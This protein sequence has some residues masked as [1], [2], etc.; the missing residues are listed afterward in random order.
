MKRIGAVLI[1]L[2]AFVAAAYPFV[3]TSSYFR[4]VGVLTLM[5]AALATSWNI[6]G[7]FTGYISLGHS[8]FFGVGAY[9]AGLLITRLSVPSYASV[10]IAGVGVG[11]AAVAVGYVAVRVRGASFVI[12]TIA[13]VYITSLLAQGWRG[14]TG[15]SQGLTVP[16]PIDV[17]RS[18][19][20]VFFYFLFL[21]LLGAV[22]FLWS[23]IGRSKFGMG[24]KAIR[25]DEDKAES[26]GVPTTAYKVVAFGLSCGLTAV[27]GAF[28][29]MWFGFLDPIF[30]FSVVISANTVLMALLGGIRHL[31]G[32]VLGALII[33]PGTEYFLAEYGATQAHLVA[34]G[35]LLGVV[36]LLMP[37]GI[38]PALRALAS[39]RHPTVSIRE[40]VPDPSEPRIDAGAA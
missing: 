7:G 21:V 31:W 18:E 13:L 19:R 30:V 35:L 28:Y 12:V 27:A 1:A 37:H 36:V 17:G 23:F 11:L 10:L 20:H 14:L 33:I 34:S 38:I 6:M 22:L 3:I 26:L 29:G 40:A 16:P 5:Y 24:L 15:G 8:A 25:E 4:F 2:G 9:T 32:P 39:R